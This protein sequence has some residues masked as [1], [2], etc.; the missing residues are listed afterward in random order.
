MSSI[1]PPVRPMVREPLIFPVFFPIRFLKPCII[2]L[3]K[4]FT[5]SRNN[6][7]GKRSKIEI[8]NSHQAAQMKLRG[9]FLEVRRSQAGSSLNNDQGK[10][11]LIK[12]WS[13]KWC[14]FARLGEGNK[15]NGKYGMENTQ[16]FHFIFGS[17]IG[18]SQLSLFFNSSKIGRNMQENIFKNFFF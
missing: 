7:N 5:I 2:V 12:S 11:T 16:S 13:Q 8:Q 15:G 6:V 1:R 9:C 4:C 10:L 3:C 14:K 17:L 18:G